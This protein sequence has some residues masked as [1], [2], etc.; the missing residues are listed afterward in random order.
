MCQMTHFVTHVK[1][2]K[3]ATFLV[4]CATGGTEWKHTFLCHMTRLKLWVIWFCSNFTCMWYK[5]FYR[6]VWRDLRLSMSIQ[7]NSIQFIYFPSLKTA[8]HIKMS[9]LATLTCCKSFNSKFTPKIDFL[10][11][12]FMLPLLMLILEV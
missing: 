5:H 10:I 11:G 9:E 6:N 7:F 1:Y 2:V 4:Q 12:H 3:W 8:K